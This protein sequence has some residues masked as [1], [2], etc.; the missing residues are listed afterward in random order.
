MPVKFDAGDLSWR[1]GSRTRLP[2]HGLIARFKSAKATVYMSRP[3]T[4]S[5]WVVVAEAHVAVAGH[6]SHRLPV[7]RRGAWPRRRSLP[8]LR[9][10]DAIDG[11]CDAVFATNVVFEPLVG[12]L[13]AAASR[14]TRRPPKQGLVTSTN[15]GRKVRTNDWMIMA[16]PADL[17]ECLSA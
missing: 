6:G 4:G 7:H 9:S 13:F 2:V 5:A 12:E 8:P 14:S 1:R 11:G 3:G 15:E 10:S 16:N 17:A